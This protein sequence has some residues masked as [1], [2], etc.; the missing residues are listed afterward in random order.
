MYNSYAGKRTRQRQSKQKAG[1]TAG[2]E[3]VAGFEM[4]T[5]LGIMTKTENE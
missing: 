3:E 4:S 2:Q 1:V 5:K